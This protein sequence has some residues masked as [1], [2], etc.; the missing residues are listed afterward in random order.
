MLYVYVNIHILFHLR[1]VIF[2]MFACLLT[3]SLLPGNLFAACPGSSHGCSYSKSSNGI[4]AWVVLNFQLEIMQTNIH[5][6]IFRVSCTA[7]SFFIVSTVL[8]ATS[9]G[10]SDSNTCHGFLA[11]Y[12]K[13]HLQFS[14]WFQKSQKIRKKEPPPGGG[15]GG[16]SFLAVFLHRALL[17]ESQA[18]RKITR[19]HVETIVYAEFPKASFIQAFYILKK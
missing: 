11:V 15:E 17:W 5:L 18:N 19:F 2:T 1:H 4:L 16:G 13:F 12:H 6:Q 8:C 10:I 9:S 3:D 14:C 7:L